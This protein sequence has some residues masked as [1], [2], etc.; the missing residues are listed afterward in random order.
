[1][2]TVT[3]IRDDATLRLACNRDEL[4]TRPVARPPVE[5]A[6]GE[7]RALLPIDPVSGGTWIAVNDA[8][9]ALTL[10]NVNLETPPTN[11]V[12]HR[13]R[14]GIIPSLL[15]MTSVDEALDAAARL[16]PAL[17]PP[18]R[19]IVLD[20]HSLGDVYSDGK[21]RRVDRISHD[22]LPAMFA[23]SGLGDHIVDPP[24]RELFTRM[25]TGHDQT[26][27]TQDA[28]HPHPSPDRTELS[29]CMARSD[30]MTVSFTVIELHSDAASMRYQPGLPTNDA[31]ATTLSLALHE[32]YAS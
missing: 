19:L 15:G 26:A 22:A 32:A 30:A 23:S 27:A 12:H 17:Y 20:R 8:G 13:S 5:R 21:T 25:F 1:M 3:L 14:G 7:R 2:C 18:F 24:R 11:H 4:R 29:V 6:F 28:F 16:D 31:A 10:L 9:L